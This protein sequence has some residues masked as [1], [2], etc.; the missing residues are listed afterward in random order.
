MQEDEPCKLDGGER[1]LE[2]ALR[3]LKPD[4]INV[5]PIACAF[6]AGRTATARR[7]SVWRTTSVALSIAVVVM[8][9]VPMRSPRSSSSETAP[10]QGIATVVALPRGNRSTYFS[11]RDAV[12]TRGVDVLPASRGSADALSMRGL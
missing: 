9:T 7:A 2:A 6:E 8:M 5:D 1:E 10:H 4:I 12:L 11:T 3:G